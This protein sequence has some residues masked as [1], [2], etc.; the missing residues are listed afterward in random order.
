MRLV[1][2]KV[3]VSGFKYQLYKS[4]SLIC[5]K[6]HNN[7]IDNHVSYVYK[8]VC[9]EWLWYLNRTDMFDFT[10]LK[11]GKWWDNNNEIDIEKSVLFGGFTDSLLRLWGQEDNLFL[12][13]GIPGM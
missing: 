4:T 2:C 13:S 3:T 11:I 12:L 1:V 9:M 5:D 7:F 10:F 8:N 6:I